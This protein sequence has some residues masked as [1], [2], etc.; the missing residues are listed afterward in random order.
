[1]QAVFGENDIRSYVDTIYFN[2]DTDAPDFA[3]DST[4]PNITIQS[5]QTNQTYI[6]TV[7]LNLILSEPVTQLIVY[8]DTN[9]T[10]LPAQNT[11]LTGL[12]VGTHKLTVEAVDLAGNPGY[13]NYVQFN[14]IQPT[15]TRS[16]H[17]QHP[18]RL[19]P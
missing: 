8:L 10:I 9:K 2:I 15:P 1:M 19:N 18:P 14:V 17:S 16:Q 13:T 11:T 6:I 4:P 12:T 7:P 5:P 3:L